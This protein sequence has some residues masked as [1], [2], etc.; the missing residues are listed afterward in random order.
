VRAPRKTSLKEIDDCLQKNLTWVTTH[1]EKAARQQEESARAEKLTWEEME[2]LGQEALRVIPPL[3]RQYA[4]TVGVNFGRITVRNQKTR[5]GSCSTKGNLNFNVL[6]MLCPREIL[7]YV[8]VHELCHRKEMN[9][10]PRFWGEVERVLPDYKA[11]RKWLKT[12]GP[13]LMARMP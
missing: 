13:V 2:A 7:E 5:W 12:N 1:L 3:V 8:I 10:S 4:G 6:L 9:H 11:R